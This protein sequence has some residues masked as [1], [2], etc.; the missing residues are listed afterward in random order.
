MTLTVHP[1]HARAAGLCMRGSRAW[2]K[3]H[4]IPWSDFV[5]KGVS[6]ARL[7]QTGDPLAARA[8]A[9]ARKEADHGRQ[10]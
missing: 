6:A 3:A 4:G 1:R 9:A 7:E 10:K 2:F 8:V 5:S